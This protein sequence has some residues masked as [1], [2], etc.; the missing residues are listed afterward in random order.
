MKWTNKGHQYDLLGKKICNIGV[1]NIAYLV[2]GAGT[3]GI[4]F[5]ELFCNEIKIEGFIDSNPKK[6]GT[7]VCGI[8]VYSPDYLEEHRAYVLVSAGWTKEIYRK[9][10]KY[11]YVKEKDYLHIDD[12]SSLY[13]W[14]KY[15]KVYLSDITYMITEKCSLNCKKCNSFIPLMVDPKN[16]PMSE[17]L[18]HFEEFFKYVDNVNILGIVGGDAMMHPDFSSIL[19]EL[20]NRYYPKKAAHIEAYCNG[21]VIPNEYTLHIMK[22]YDVFYRFT[23][24]RP[25]T[26]GRQRIEE[27]IALLEEYG[28]RY[29]HVRFEKWCDCGYPQE[30][31][32][33]KGEEELIQFF[34]SC[35]RKS[36][37]ALFDG[38]V[39][40]CGMVRAAHR[41]DYCEMSETDKFDISYYDQDRKIELIEFM[42]GYSEKGY[43]NYC[44]KCNGSF[45]VNTKMIEAGEQIERTNVVM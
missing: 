31:N 34:D 18:K 20:G 36:C 10:E 4:S 17:I 40:N 21:V 6:Q 27:I 29:D 19:E 30:S 37:H 43:L 41:I 39:L 1:E 12:F 8:P 14:Y 25:Y 28:I 22:K 11:G 38:Y 26:K 16:I 9:L 5:Y 23:D 24:Y 32:G 15:G 7:V 13:Y 45:N 2:W 35:D 44:K 3:F 33:I 42:L